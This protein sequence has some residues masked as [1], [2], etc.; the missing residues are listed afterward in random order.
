[1]TENNRLLLI[2][3]D[4]DIIDSLLASNDCFHS[5][6]GFINDGGEFLNPSPNYLHEIK[7]RLLTHPEEYPLAVDHLI[8]IKD[9]KTVVGTIYF[10]SLP[11]EGK[12]EIGYG[13]SPQYEGN[14]YMSEA[15]FLMLNYGKSLG[16][17]TVFADTTKENVKSQNVLK[18]NGFILCKEKENFLHFVKEL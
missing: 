17:T 11:I 1:M 8:V 4:V 10:K 18:R 13:M 6:Y 14:G 12:T 3:I 15:L 16:I 5:K 9:I 2:P 7:E